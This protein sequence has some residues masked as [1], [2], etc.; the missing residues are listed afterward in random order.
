MIIH[1]DLFKSVLFSVRNNL[2]HLVDLIWG[3]APAEL[4]VGLD[5]AL[6]LIDLKVLLGVHIWSE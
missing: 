6:L 4:D 5:A 3:D 2:R 1:T